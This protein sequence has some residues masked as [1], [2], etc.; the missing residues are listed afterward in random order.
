[1]AFD[2][3]SARPWR[4]EPSLLHFWMVDSDEGTVAHGCHEGDAK[5]IVRAVNNSDALVDLLRRIA[6]LTDGHPIDANRRD[7]INELAR[8][9]LKLLEA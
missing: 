3:P 6:N 1:M 2:K 8:E 9:A 5:L 4:A 7:R